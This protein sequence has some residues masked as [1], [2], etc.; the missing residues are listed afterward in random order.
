MNK[1]SH[2]EAPLLARMPLGTGEAEKKQ[3]KRLRGEATLV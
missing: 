2:Q 1:G 3:A